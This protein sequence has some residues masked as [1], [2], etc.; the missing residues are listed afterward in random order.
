MEIC[1]YV[2]FIVYE[3]SRSDALT[4]SLDGSNLNYCFAGP[5]E[6]GSDDF[7]VLKGSHVAT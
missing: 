3:E 7:L 4:Q 5:F 2:T 1:D 6:D